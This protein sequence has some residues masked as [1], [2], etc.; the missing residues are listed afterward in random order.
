MIP[1]MEENT[2]HDNIIIA[3]TFM[4][5]FLIVESIYPNIKDRSN[6]FVM[7]T[8]INSNEILNKKCQTVTSMD[9]KNTTIE[10][11]QNINKRI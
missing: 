6:I 5:L 7:C 11:I 3:T 2:Y 9:L 1:K 10:V 8:S 4:K